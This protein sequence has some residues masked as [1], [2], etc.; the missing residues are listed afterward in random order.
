[1]QI[2][3]PTPKQ[4]EIVTCHYAQSQKPQATE[5]FPANFPII[6]GGWL[7]KIQK[8]RINQFRIWGTLTLLTN[9]ERSTNTKNNTDTDKR[10]WGLYD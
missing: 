4:T 5:Y 9:A 10:T 6:T 8:P 7:A 2:V 1:M 3:A